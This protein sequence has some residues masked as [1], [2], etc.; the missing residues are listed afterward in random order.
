MEGGDRSADH[1]GGAVGV[2]ADSVGITEAESTTRKPHDG[3]W[4]RA[5]RWSTTAMAS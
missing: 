2:A 5:R 1:D 3:A 4:S